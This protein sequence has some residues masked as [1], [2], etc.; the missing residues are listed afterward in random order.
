MK[1]LFRP[2]EAR[3][4][5]A[6]HATPDDVAPMPGTI[7]DDHAIGGRGDDTDDFIFGGSTASHVEIYGIDD[8]EPRVER[9]LLCAG[10]DL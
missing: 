1:P 8:A 4:D 3:I 7:V 9:V 2:Q 10:S 5:P 6:A